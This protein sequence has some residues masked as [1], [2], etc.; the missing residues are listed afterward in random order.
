[1]FE[2]F[3]I[4]LPSI[5][6]F[7]F[8]L[9]LISAFDKF[10]FKI[11]CAIVVS[12]VILFQYYIFFGDLISYPINGFVNSENISYEK[13]LFYLCQITLTILFTSLITRWAPHAKYLKP[14]YSF[15]RFHVRRNVWFALALIFTMFGSE[16]FYYSSLLTFTLPMFM[17]LWYVCG[18]FIFNRIFNFAVC[19][20]VPSIYTC[21]IDSTFVQYSENNLHRLPSKRITFI[22]F[23]NTLIVMISFGLD[24]ANAI[25]YT[26]HKKPLKINGRKD[27]PTSK[28]K[29]YWDDIKSI[30]WTFHTTENELDLDHLDDIVHCFNFLQKKSSTFFAPIGLCSRGMKFELI[31]LFDALTCSIFG[32]SNKNHAESCMT[33]TYAI[34]FSTYYR[35]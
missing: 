12:Y 8:H 13:F 14:S 28:Y 15:R 17:Y 31:H 2:L 32:R 4:L 29:Y 18:A 35:Y 34:R 20:L 11:V 24:R 10:K 23:V 7:L 25:E 6:I 33:M 19:I 5:V 26:H 3:Y 16:T 1:M 9:P 22:F 21:W 30:F 27:I